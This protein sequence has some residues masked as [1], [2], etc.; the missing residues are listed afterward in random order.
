MCVFGLNSR[1]S[2]QMPVGTGVQ[3]SDRTPTTPR[4]PPDRR[5]TAPRPHG[6][7]TPTA[8]RRRHGFEAFHVDQT[9][10]TGTTFRVVTR[11]EQLVGERLL[12]ATPVG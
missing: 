4:P 5:P 7:L 1:K 11:V 12:G 9:Q 8:W 3:G 6:G 2:V 10:Q